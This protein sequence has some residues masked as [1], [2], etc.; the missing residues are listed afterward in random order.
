MSEK[1]Q[2]LVEEEIFTC[3][4]VT[5]AAPAAALRF[6]W[7]QHLSYRRRFLDALAVCETAVHEAGPMDQ[8]EEDGIQ[9]WP[10]FAK[11]TWELT[12]MG[13]DEVKDWAKTLLVRLSEQYGAVYE[14][15]DDEP[16]A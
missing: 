15:V 11:L 1:Q 8:R 13:T 9:V 12:Q 14:D 3:F 7:A 2:L 5:A 6:E 10:K 4:T 16:A